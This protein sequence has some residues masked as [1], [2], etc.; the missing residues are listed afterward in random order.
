LP[1]GRPLA[2]STAFLLDGALEPVPLGCQGEIF[3]GGSGLALGYAGAPDWTAERFVPHPFTARPGERLFRTGDRG[4]LRPDGQLEFRGRRDRQVKI[5]GMRLEP[6]EVETALT[7]HPAVR[8]A[9]VVVRERGAGDRE[10]VAYVAD[11][12]ETSAASLAEHLRRRLPAWMVPAVFVRLD[13]LPL[14][15]NG[16][17]DLERLLAT[18]ES[19]TAPGSV[20]PFVPPRNAP[21]RAMAEVWGQVLGREIGVF[22]NFFDLGGHSLH[23]IQVIARLRCLWDRELP[24]RRFFELPTVAA[25]AELFDGSALRMAG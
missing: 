17:V 6:G 5:R 15:A 16:K 22:D 20:A 4:R 21:E 18:A 7:A 13:D 8:A 1:I 2:S 11:R 24:V 19:G 25:L 23:V 14:T 3:L 12:E 10:L 9:R